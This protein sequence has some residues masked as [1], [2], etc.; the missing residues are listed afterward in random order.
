[1]ERF[2]ASQ[3]VLSEAKFWALVALLGGITFGFAIGAG[4]ALLP[5]AA[6][7]VSGLL[8]GPG[9]TGAWRPAL[10]GTAAGL[11]VGVLVALATI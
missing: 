5:A 7:A 4:N 10:S 9:A 11:V 6:F 1:M 2:A 8:A 3:P